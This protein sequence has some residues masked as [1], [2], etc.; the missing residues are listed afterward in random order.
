M[1]APTPIAMRRPARTTH[2]TPTRAAAAALVAAVVATAALAAQPARA[3]TVQRLAV[4]RN[5]RAAA[6]TQVQAAE[7]KLHRLLPAYRSL[8]RRLRDAV[9]SALDAAEARQ[10]LDAQLAA[11]RGA[12][13]AQVR[14][15]YESGNGMALQMILSARSVGEAVQAQAYAS[16]VLGQDAATAARLAVLDRAAATVEQRLQ[17]RQATVGRA[18]TRM[19]TMV[20]ELESQLGRA[21]AAAQRA[22]IQ[23][24]GLEAEQRAIARAAQ[25][26]QQQGGNL[27]NPGTVPGGGFD[28]SALLALLGPTG[29]RTCTVP[30]GLQPTGQQLSGLAS[31][32]GWAFAG[33]ATATGAIYDPRLFTAANKTLPLNSFLMVRFQ[34][35]CAVVLVNDRGPYGGGRSF[36]LSEA[37]AAYLGYQSAGVV[38]V[39]ATVLVPRNPTPG[40]PFP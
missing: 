15:A 21:R 22:G 37:V 32:Y 8:Q 36:D 35:R 1:G 28:Q 23:I 33:Q 6:L 7:R 29:G 16:A 11:V 40:Y 24:K 19:Q 14:L 39:T 20:V 13:Q 38:Q 18:A 26:A 5:S 31:W 4:A 30:G 25:Q 17:R 2:A 3:G 34:G 10:Q 9:R 27:G 12:L